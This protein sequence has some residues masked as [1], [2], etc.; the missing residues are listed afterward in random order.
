MKKWHGIPK[1]QHVPVSL[2]MKGLAMKAVCSMM[3][4]NYFNEDAKLIQLHNLW[5][6]VRLQLVV[7]FAP[8]K[9]YP[10]LILV[11]ERSCSIQS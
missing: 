1:G 10:I 8:T 5:D 11:L 7:W 6:L 9:V 2:H 3:F 4:G